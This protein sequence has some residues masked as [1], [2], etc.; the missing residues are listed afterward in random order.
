MISLL[1]ENQWLN[2]NLSKREIDN[3]K[4]SE[5]TFNRMLN[6]LAILH[7]CIENNTLHLA[8]FKLSVGTRK[9]L[10]EI[11]KH[12]QQISDISLL[13]EA[14]TDPVSTA[15]TSKKILSLI[16]KFHT[17]N[18]QYLDNVG[19]DARLKDISLPKNIGAEPSIIQKAALK[20]KELGGKAGQIA[21]TLFQSIVVNALNRFVKWSSTL[22]S[23]ILDAKKQG[24]AWQMIMAKLGPS[25][26]IAK[27]AANGTITYETD[28][29]G[30]SMLSKL[31]D[32][33]KLNPKWT[34]AIIGLLINITKILSVS[35]A[36]STVGTSLAIGVLVGLL[37]RTV[38]GHY[39]KNEPWETAFKKSLVVTGLS[40]VGGSLTKGLFS[41]F[42]GGGFID[43]A[44]SY[45]T[46]D[47]A[48]AISDQNVISGN[49]KVSEVD[50]SKLMVP[51]LPGGN[52]KLFD[53]ISTN[54]K[55]YDAFKEE[56]ESQNFSADLSGI[57]Q[58]LRLTANDDISVVINGAGGL[59][60]NLLNVAADAAS[61]MKI[62][63]SNTIA[64][65][66]LMKLKPNDFA[67]Q[68]KNFAETVDNNDGI[69]VLK[70]FLKTKGYDENAVNAIV[71]KL[72][73]EK[74]GQIDSF[75]DWFD[76]RESHTD[77]WLDWMSRRVKNSGI[78]NGA[79]SKSTSN[80]ADVASQAVTRTAT[81][82]TQSLKKEL[83][84]LALGGDAKAADDY[85][86]EFLVSGRGGEDQYRILKT[87][88][89]AGIID[90]QQFYS[91]VGTKTLNLTAELRGHIPISINGVNV[92]DKLTPDEAKAAHVAMSVAKQAGSAVDEDALAK[93]A[94]KAA[95]KVG[96]AV[97][98]VAGDIDMETLKMPNISG[99][100]SQLHKAFPPDQPPTA[101][102]L[103]KFFSSKGIDPKL[104][105]DLAKSITGGDNASSIEKFRDL[106]R[107]GGTNG[108]TT[109]FNKLKLMGNLP[110]D[111]YDKLM[112]DVAATAASGLKKITG[113]QLKTLNQSLGYGNLIEKLEDPEYYN[114]FLKPALEKMYPGSEPDR[115]L[116]SLANSIANKDVSQENLDI[117]A[118]VINSAGGLPQS[119]V[120]STVKESVYKT[121]IKKLYI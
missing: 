94:T 93:L 75:S 38:S 76:A 46:G 32:F 24:S 98:S 14:A 102:S 91:G 27:R 36:G 3:F 78:L 81:G 26:K 15:D 52:P 30:T 33:T 49:V 69:E 120:A 44:K 45:F 47:A 68:L 90:K 119:I 63:A 87:A 100:T 22:K 115:V 53:I 61:A 97:T 66:D 121:L 17:D 64:D 40:L 12:N 72:V 60:K 73:G 55:L 39:L 29:S 58:Y 104:A 8:E 74:A 65:I 110:K 118:K 84:K 71:K 83:G 105:K 57:K 113:E 59:P 10:R 117:F 107:T 11:Y 18:K 41:Y 88:L 7:G 16:N 95:A 37:I 67:D 109:I 20:T 21:I 77:K 85:M 48:T 6:E 35:L 103:L 112:S 28:S 5:F 23:D 108:D 111:Q 82:A 51:K 92:I 19:S 86:Q 1:G 116:T 89:D 101:D 70:S 31:Q 13:V 2:L 25:M 4:K 56:A 114:K 96:K 50:I 34:N 54:K 43:G 80:A 9:T 42:K 106:W 62:G 79:A 99:L